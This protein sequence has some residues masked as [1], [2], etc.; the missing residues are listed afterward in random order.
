MVV[1]AVDVDPQEEAAAVAAFAVEMDHWAEAVVV[2]VAVEEDPWFRSLLLEAEMN[3][4]IDPQRFRSLDLEEETAAMIASN[5]SRSQRPC[6]YSKWF[7]K[8][9]T[10]LGFPPTQHSLATL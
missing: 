7:R 9:C 2:V 6:S 4:K 10:S 3:L 8:C 5:S 1:V